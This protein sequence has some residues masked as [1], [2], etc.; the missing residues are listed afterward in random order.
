MKKRFARYTKWLPLILSMS[1]AM[2]AVAAGGY[3]GVQLIDSMRTH[4]S[5]SV[6]IA[7]ATS[8][9]NNP[10][11]C[12]K[13]NRVVLPAGHAYFREMYASILAAQVRAGP[14]M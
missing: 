11:A 6:S 3:S 8:K 2:P 5:G 9:W 4:A 7:G 1:A 14:R 12:K 13:N 10:D